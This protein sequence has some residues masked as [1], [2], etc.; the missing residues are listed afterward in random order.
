MRQSASAPENTPPKRRGF[1]AN[2]PE[3]WRLFIASYVISTIW[4][5]LVAL[6]VYAYLHR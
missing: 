1:F 5:S 3:H 4:L 2:I 6:I